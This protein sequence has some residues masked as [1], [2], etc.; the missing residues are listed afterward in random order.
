VKKIVLLT[1]LFAFAAGLVRSEPGTAQSDKVVSGPFNELELKQFASLEPIDTHVHNFHASPVFNALINRLNLRMIDV[2]VIDSHDAVPLSKSLP[3]QREAALSVI[4]QNQ[5]RMKLCT[6][7]NPYDFNHSDFA[8]NAVRGLNQDFANGAIAVKIWKNIGMEIKNAKGQ[9]ILPDDPKFDPIY[10]DI[11][12]H[13]K[14]LIAH[15]ADPNTIWAPPDPKADDYDYYMVEAPWWY[16][17]TKPGAPSKES[18]LKARDHI[19]EKHPHLRLV[20]AHTGSMEAN[21]DDLG[22]HFDRYPNLAVDLAGRVVYFEM[23]QRDKA[24]AFITKYQD[25]LIYGTDNDHEFAP[26]ANEKQSAKDWEEAYANQWRFLATNDVVEYQ[27]KP[28]KGLALPAPILRKL[29]HDN[30][31]RWFPGI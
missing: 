21:L 8:E 11:E 31:K 17:Y 25:R 18:L 1:F 26:A 16:M 14:T 29:Y 5:S 20:G 2:L 27:G 4:D 23:M 15:V 7:F 13:G 24:I 28:V 3:L 9:Y 6:T 10:A 30:A 22:A 12:A 19:L